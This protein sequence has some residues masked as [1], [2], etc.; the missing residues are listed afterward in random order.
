MANIPTEQL[1]LLS[2]ALELTRKAHEIVTNL[3][4]HVGPGTMEV[5]SGLSTSLAAFK[6]LVED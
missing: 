2:E 6:V 3:H 4:L 5:A 1:Q